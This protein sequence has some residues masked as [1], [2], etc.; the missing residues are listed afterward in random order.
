MYNSLFSIFL[1]LFTFIASSINGTFSQFTS[2]SSNNF[3]NSS[4][5]VFRVFTLKYIL[6]LSVLASN[7]SSVN[8]LPK[9]LIQFLTI[10]LL[11]E[12]F[13]AKLSTVSFIF[14]S[15]ISSFCLITFLKTAFTNP[16]DLLSN[17]FVKF[18]VS[19][20]AA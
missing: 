9:L 20:T 17:F 11:Y 12:Y 10:H 1:R 4:L 3:I 18:T 13:V 8:S 6:G 19:L 16:A 5:V 15:P 2:C 7:K 14:T